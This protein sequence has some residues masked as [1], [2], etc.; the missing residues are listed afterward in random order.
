VARERWSSRFGFVMATAGFAVGL[1]NIWRFPYL[2]GENGGAAFLI[3]Y[4]AF[5][6]LIGI[7]LMTSEISLGRKSQLSPI[8]GMG[9]LTG[10]ATSPWN[11]I[12][13]MGVTTALLI[14]SYYIMLVAWIVGYLVMMA[15][16]QFAGA[17]PEQIQSVYSAF[18][19]RPLPVL[20]YSLLLVTLL[21]IVL[22]R[23][24]TRG[25]ERVAKIAMPLLLVLLLLLVLRSLTLPGAGEGLSWYLKPD[26]SKLSGST[27][28]AALGQAFY[29]IGIG[30][31]AAFGFGS[32]LHAQ[33]SDVPGNAVLVVAFDTGVAFIAGLV[34]F[35][36]LFAFGIPPDSGPGLLFVTMPNLFGQMPA[37][38][39]LGT[40]FFFLV[41]LAA[42]TSA[43]ALFEVLSK[44]LSDSLHLGRT[45]SVVITVGAVYVLSVPIVLSQGP[46]SHMRVFGRDL[47]G[48]TDHV[49]GTYMLAIGG[50]LTA[51]YVATVWG[52]ASFRDETN[53]GSGPIKVN[54]SWMPFVR[55][56]IPVAV[57]L[58]LLSGLASS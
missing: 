24:L 47:F 13:W 30:M 20:G 38:Q 53:I 33:R 23:G 17:S 15:T 48:I 50:L 32:Y 26:F 10:K 40:A 43:I 8:A 21:G 51:L 52:W 3:V 2:A 49:T 42:V 35:P 57:G 12:G 16:G 7:P 34:I 36:A 55:L 9:K 28:L 14:Q 39:L 27:L 1:G 56:I 4:L 19:S 22:A 31:A 25:V 11:L 44:T 29:S 41:T 54:A 46:W 5:A 58:V 45:V 6:T 37:G 18:V